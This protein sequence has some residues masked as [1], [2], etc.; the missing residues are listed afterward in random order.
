MFQGIITSDI[1]LA[2]GYKNEIECPDEYRILKANRYHPRVIQMLAREPRIT[3]HTDDWFKQRKL[4]I[5]ASNIASIIGQNKYCS[6]RTLF[7]RKT[8]Q[9]KPQGM[10]PACT[11][12]LDHEDEAAARFSEV[13]GIDLVEEDIGLM[14]HKQYNF[15]GASPDFVC[16][17]INALIEIKCPFRRTITHDCPEH[18]YPQVQLQ[19]EVCDIDLCYFVQYRPDT[20]TRHGILDIVKVPRDKMWFAKWLPHIQEFW[21]EVLTYYDKVGKPVGSYTVDWKAK[22]REKKLKKEQTLEIPRRRKDEFL[23]SDTCDFV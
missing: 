2:K 18:Y 23:N 1:P 10:N 14:I 21:N 5:T 13:T 22:E 15:I 7:K 16:K 20:F 8:G 9:L 6:R 19:L 12:G 4:R 11:Y 17:Y 3:Q